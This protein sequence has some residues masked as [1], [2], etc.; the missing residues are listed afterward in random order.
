MEP[1]K[2]GY[3]LAHHVHVCRVNDAVIFLDTQSDSY[4]AVVGEQMQLPGAV[5]QSWPPGA[6]SRR[7]AR[8][9]E[10]T[11]G[12][13][14]GRETGE[15]YRVEVELGLRSGRPARIGDYS[16]IVGI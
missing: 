13:C 6:R 2:P 4:G 11:D 12:R 5:V 8:P 16:Q 3:W 14:C 9:K 1:M 15:R 7:A 10:D